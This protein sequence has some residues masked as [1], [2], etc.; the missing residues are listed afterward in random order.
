MS[1]L[2]T[3]ENSKKTGKWSIFALIV[4]LSPVSLATSAPSVEEAVGGRVSDALGANL[5]LGGALAQPSQRLAAR[6][7][8]RALYLPSLDLNAR[9]SRGSGGRTIDFPVGDLLN[10]V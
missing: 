4:A 8:A 9:Y 5:Q 1:N 6:D 7:Q 3:L 2:Y 10:P